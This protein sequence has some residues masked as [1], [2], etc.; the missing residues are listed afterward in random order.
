MVIV[1]GTIAIAALGARMRVE[2][3]KRTLTL[4]WMEAKNNRTEL[5]ASH[6]KVKL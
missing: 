1:D 2:T 6:K 3:M 5:N 4:I